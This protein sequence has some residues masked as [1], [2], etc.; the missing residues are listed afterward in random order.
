MNAV[1]KLRGMPNTTYILASRAKVKCF[2]KHRTTEVPK[3]CKSSVLYV[4]LL[5]DPLIIEI[6]VTFW[7]LWRIC[8]LINDVWLCSVDWW[9]MNW[10]EL[11][12]K[13]ALPNEHDITAFV[14]NIWAKLSNS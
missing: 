11:V 10:D 7:D 6:R 12:R 9:K 3:C 13:G 14:C 5:R 4:S 8:V 1:V 2:K